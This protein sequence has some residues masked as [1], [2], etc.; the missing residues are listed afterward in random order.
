[1]HYQAAPNEEAKLVRCTRGA[2]QDVIVDLRAN[3]PT[4]RDHFS[5]ELTAEN[6]KMLYVPE[7]F[8]HGFITLEDS[9]EVFY[10]MSEFF[11][12]ESARGFR[13][14]DPFF[15]IE[16]PIEVSVISERDRTYPDFH[17]GI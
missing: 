6:R 14:D 15:R 7:G 16:L 10:Q 11:V 12:A 5:V 4:Y 17:P 8:A 13:W 2:L 9:T 1:M 3:S